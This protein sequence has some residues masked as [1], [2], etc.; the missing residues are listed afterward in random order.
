M[1]SDRLMRFTRAVDIDRNKKKKI[2]FYFVLIFIFLF[3]K[4]LDIVCAPH[5]CPAEKYCSVEAHVVYS[6]L[7]E[8][9]ICALLASC[10]SVSKL[11]TLHAFD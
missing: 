9:L 8:N 2:L 5:S 7:L 11:R 1:K 10:R 6:C 3:F 4:N